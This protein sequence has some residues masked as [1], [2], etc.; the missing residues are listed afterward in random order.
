MIAAIIAVPVFMEV[1]DTTIAQVALRNIAGN[2]G[3]GNDESTWV[4]T[5]YLV[6]NAV[7]LPISGWL[8]DV[9]GRKRFFVASVALFTVASFLCGSATSLPMLVFFRVLQGLGGGG[10]API[11]QAMLADSFPPEKRGAAF[12]IWAIAVILSPVLGP[13]LGGWITDTYSWPWIFYINVP[14]GILSV[15]LCQ[16]FLVEPTLLIRERKRRWQE[17]IR[18]D[19]VGFVLAAVGLACLEI[20]MS[21]GEQKDWFAS[22]LVRTAATISGTSL[23]LMVI[24]EWFHPDP[25]VDVSLFRGRVFSASFIVMFGGSMVLY[26]ANTILPM[27]MQVVH[28]YTA[29]LAGLVLTPGGA[30]SAVGMVLVGVMTRFVQ[31]RYLVAFGVITQIIPSYCM[32]QFTPDLTF[33]HA[34]WVRLFQAFGLGFLFVPLIT[35]SYHG[36]AADKTN[37]A[38]AVMNIS[39]N[40]GGSIGISMANTWI[41]WRTQY[42][43]SVLAEHISSYNGVAQRA[44]AGIQSI[45]GGGGTDGLVDGRTMLALDGMVNH[46]AVVMA[47]N[48]VFL[49]SAGLSV[50]VLLLVAL[51]PRNEV[52]QGEI[53][54]H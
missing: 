40:I 53:A 2:L 43:H 47:Y 34:A 36:L 12:S 17:G 13:P 41:A 54:M 27:L 5:S 15:I 29:F 7:I 9:M 26:S 22:G 32:S 35:L 18:L 42:H 52:G 30:V 16:M 14:V 39:R 23:L 48:D 31:L 1:L 21:K 8:A 37:G 19:Y 25:V 24:W 50:V 28:G 46:Q 6:A 44:I 45:A 10:T 4:V 20:T 49:L 11:S 38:S 51:L 3:A 33:W